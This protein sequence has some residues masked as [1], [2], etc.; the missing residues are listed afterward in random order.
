MPTDSSVRI[1]RTQGGYAENLRIITKWDGTNYY[2][3]AEIIDESWEWILSTG[4]YLL[5][6]DD[7]YIEFDLK[8]ATSP[9]ANDG[10]LSLWVNGIFMETLT[11]IENYGHWVDEVHFGPHSSIMSGSLYFDSFESRRITYIGPIGLPLEPTFGDVPFEHPF[12]VYIEALWDA[13]FTAGCT[14]DPLMFC[15]ELV[16]DR[17]QSAVFMLRGQFGDSYVPPVEPWGTFAD[18]WTLGI[19]AEKWAEG[20]WLEGFTAGC[21]A[22]DDPPIYC[23][24]DQLPREQAAVFGLRMMHGMEYTPP[25]A[26][27]T[28]FADMTDTTYWATKWAE[29]AYLDG[30]L[31]ECGMQ[32]GKPLFCPYNLLDRAGGAFLISKAKDLP[33]LMP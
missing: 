26:T 15:P 10:Y 25:P 11:G 32:D 12:Y 9:G 6:S 29:Q 18:D 22:L 30:L 13:G 16:M 4:E 33:L 19:W 24:W 27:G 23:P 8:F 1:F 31:P 28:L 7:S 5:P 21:Q 17:A 3:S 20:M 14:A 2:I